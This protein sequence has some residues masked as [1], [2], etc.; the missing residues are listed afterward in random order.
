[1]YQI[2]AEINPEP[3]EQRRRRA[4][5]HRSNIDVAGP[6]YAWSMDAHC[7]F[8][9][10][11]IQIYAAID[12]YSRFVTWIYV[13]ITAR[14]AISVLA[15]YIKTLAED[16]MM[17]LKIRTDH[18]LETLEMA[19]AHWEI[20]SK[21]RC[22]DDGQPLQF[23]DCY[24][25]G[26]SRANVRIES[27]WNQLT[28]TMLDK[29]RSFFWELNNTG[30]FVKDDLVDRI[31]FMTIYVPIIREEVFEF[32]RLWNT[33]KIRKQ[34]RESHVSGIPWILYHYPELSNG[35]QCGVEVEEELLLS[36]QAD[37]AD[38]GMFEASD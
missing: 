9:H 2:A 11:G 30:L 27:W 24:R 16:G 8:E 31:A 21:K 23:E 37:I 28:R 26:T 17:P 34:K 3:L 20:S 6:N 29:W 18:G 5:L 1:M 4:R 35:I 14:T 10:F 32:T 25:F 38:F 19:R 13:G 33:H 22:R 7:K 15:Q 36:Y 12:V